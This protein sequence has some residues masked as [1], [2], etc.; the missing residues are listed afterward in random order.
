M[1]RTLIGSI[2]LGSVFFGL[3]I[4]RAADQPDGTVR[5]T[6]T[7]VAAGVGVSWGSG[8]LTYKEKEYPFS[9][10]GFSAGDIGLT[11]AELSG[12]VFYLKNLEDFNGTFATLSAGLTI[13][14]GAAA[15]T[16]R[17]QNGVVLNIVGT[18]QGLNFKFG[19]DGV[20][21]VLTK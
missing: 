9:I 20:K 1:R 5:F 6:A 14:G 3:T 11:S 2:I 13:A 4:A 10:N 15:A 16:M 12:E 19:V 8:V 21:I 18:T 7:S 17:N